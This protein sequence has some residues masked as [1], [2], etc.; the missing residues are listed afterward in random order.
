M[1]TQKAITV[2]A[3][4]E[5]YVR[6]IQEASNR[7]F[8][9]HLAILWENGKYPTFEIKE[10]V[11]FYKIISVDSQ[12]SV[13]CFVEKATGDIYKAATWSQPAKGVRGNIFDEKPP[14]TSSSLYK[15]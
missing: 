15:R 13:F 10:G 8:Q 1:D 5:A 14:L 11:R 3:G 4:V 7:H 2:L 9:I 12:T 6:Q